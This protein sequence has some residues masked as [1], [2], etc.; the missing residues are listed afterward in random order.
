MF[1]STDLG[2]KTIITFRKG[3][4]IFQRKKKKIYLE[5]FFNISLK[6]LIMISCYKNVWTYAKSANNLY[7]KKE[8]Q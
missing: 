1:N 4:F 3:V 8:L 2:R 5:T 7:K 6:E